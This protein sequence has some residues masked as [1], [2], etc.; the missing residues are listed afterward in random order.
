MSSFKYAGDITG[1]I[2]KIFPGGE[3]I[4]NFSPK[5]LGEAYGNLL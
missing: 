5:A 3:S 1:E 2:G 4:L